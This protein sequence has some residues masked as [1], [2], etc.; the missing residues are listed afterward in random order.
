MRAAVYHGAADVRIAELERPVP[1]PSEL[2]VE[3]R[4]CGICGSDLMDWYI[5][6]RAPLVL[7]HEPVGVV[8]EAG[9]GADGSLPAPGARVFVHH[10]VPCQACELCRR[11]HETLCET[12][13]RTRILPGG[14]SELFLVPAE[15]AALDV[16]EV[17]AHVTDEAA[18][19]IEPLACVVRGQRIAGVGPGTRLVVVGAGQIGLLQALAGR[20]AGAQVTVV[21][22]VQ[23]RRAFAERLGFAAVAPDATSVID[24]GGGAR[25]TVVTLCTGAASAWELAEAVVDRGGIVQ[26]FAP[27]RPGQR[28]SFEGHDLFFREVTIQ[29]SYSAGP[30]DTR[31]ALHLIASGAVDADVLISHRFELADTGRAL[32]TARGED[33]VKVVVTNGASA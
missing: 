9:E 6:S 5:D 27:P 33:A 7:G 23:C 28:R 20:A 11:G 31:A 12:F 15:N 18:T 22:L 19:A 24:A 16:L 14:F 13:R 1:G 2:L 25:P 26:L 32:A 8:L 10:H 29:A 4:A 30:R 3:M 17:P 21:E